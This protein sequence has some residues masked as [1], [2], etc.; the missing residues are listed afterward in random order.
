MNLILRMFS[1]TNEYCLPKESLSNFS[2]LKRS[3]GCLSIFPAIAD[4]MV[5]CAMLGLSKAF[6]LF[7]LIE[8]CEVLDLASKTVERHIEFHWTSSV[9]YHLAPDCKG[10]VFMLCSMELRETSVVQRGLNGVSLISEKY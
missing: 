7:D 5:W 2:S 1:S 4:T 9:A 8:F 6:F 3:R 10:L